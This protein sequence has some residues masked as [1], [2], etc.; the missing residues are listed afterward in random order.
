L[1][2]IKFG[3]DTKLSFENVKWVSFSKSSF[4]EILDFSGVDEVGFLSCD[5]SNV[6]EMKFKE[7]A[8]L[9]I[10]GNI[11]EDF[12]FS[13]FGD[14]TFADCDL[15]NLKKLKFRDGARVRFIEDVHCDKLLAVSN[16]G[17][18]YFGKTRIGR[19]EDEEGIL[20]DMPYLKKIKFK[21]ISQMKKSGIA[22]D[23]RKFVFKESSFGATARKIAGILGGMDK[24]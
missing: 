7:G 12:D 17:E 2:G 19:E 24:D 22:R 5:F 8:K 13:L 15:T 9:T 18:V 3:K 21:N 6:K 1:S 10:T 23:Y 14:V 20:Y 11:P 4:P 16:C